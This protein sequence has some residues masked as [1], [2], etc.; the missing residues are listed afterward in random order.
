[1]VFLMFYNL[2]SIF[3]F[4]EK[5]HVTQKFVHTIFKVNMIGMIDLKEFK[6][7][8]LNKQYVDSINKEEGQT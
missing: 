5:A 4:N 3:K 7:M 2:F 1:M 6:D 8:L